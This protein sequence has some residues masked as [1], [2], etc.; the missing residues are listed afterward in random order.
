MEC[1]ASEASSA[2]CI[3]SIPNDK[4]NALLDSPEFAD[5]LANDFTQSGEDSVSA[6]TD[7]DETESAETSEGQCCLHS[8]E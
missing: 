4:N 5:V 1:K 2:S 6:D 8:V 3:A 7:F